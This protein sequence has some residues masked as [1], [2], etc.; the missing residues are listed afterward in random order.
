MGDFHAEKIVPLTAEQNRIVVAS[1]L[2]K[3]QKRLMVYYTEPK[4]S[5]KV[6]IETG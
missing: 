5:G 4:S 2:I 6:R 1:V 3:D